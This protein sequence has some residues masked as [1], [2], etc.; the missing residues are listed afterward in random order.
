MILKHFDT[1][2]QTQT[3]SKY[4]NILETQKYKQILWRHTNTN[5]YSG[6]TQIKT[7][8]NKYSRDTQIQTNTNKY[9]RDTQIQTN[10]LQT[11]KRFVGTHT[12]TGK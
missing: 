4:T 9:S 11:N 6:D 5:K 2:L 10:T 12:N 3:L 8:T 7:N 1:K